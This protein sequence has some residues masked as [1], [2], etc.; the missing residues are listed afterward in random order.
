M[1]F[2]KEMVFCDII[3][4]TIACNVF[5]NSYQLKKYLAINDVFVDHW[6]Y[7]VNM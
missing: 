3:L 6:R 1:Y 5:I 4:Y 7:I 2:L